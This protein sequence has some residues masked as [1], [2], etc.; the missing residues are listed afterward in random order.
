MFSTKSVDNTAREMAVKAL[1]E[2]QDLQ[3]SMRQVMDVQAELLDKL[4][5]L[6]GKVYAH[7]MH[8]PEDP[9]PATR[10]SKAELLRKAGFTPGRPMIHHKEE[11]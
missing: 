10:E 8:L 5:R 11:G 2:L 7:K 6:R 9:G 3:R 1:T 4:Q